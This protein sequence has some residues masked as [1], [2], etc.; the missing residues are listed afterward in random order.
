MRKKA[1]KSWISSF[2]SGFRFN[3]F[4]PT[5]VATLIFIGIVKMSLPAFKA[6]RDFEWIGNPQMPE[7]MVK[8]LLNVHKDL[9]G[10]GFR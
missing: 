4:L 10:L 9:H 2:V 5:C 3:C 1:R 7:W 8:V 6:L